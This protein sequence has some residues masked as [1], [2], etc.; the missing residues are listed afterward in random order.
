MLQHYRNVS[1]KDDLSITALYCDNFK[2]FDSLFSQNTV[3]SRPVIKKATQK[4]E[5]VSTIAFRD[6]P[7]IRD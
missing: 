1:L 5:K 7:V 4:A 3:L 6:L 2:A